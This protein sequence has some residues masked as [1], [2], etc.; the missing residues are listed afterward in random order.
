MNIDLT[1]TKS[2]TMVKNLHSICCLVERNIPG[3]SICVEQP[4]VKQDYSPGKLRVRRYDSSSVGGRKIL[5]S[6]VKV[7]GNMMGYVALIMLEIA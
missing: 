3:M 6:Q 5:P 2:M 1:V 7:E 4:C